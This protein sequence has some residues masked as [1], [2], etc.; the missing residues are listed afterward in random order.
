MTTRSLTILIAEDTAAT[1]L[2]LTKTIKK[3]GHHPI[4]A[5]NGQ[6]AVELFVQHQPDLVLCDINMPVMNG[7]E[8]IR[9]I[10]R[11]TTDY[12]APIL[13]LSASDQDDD[14]VRGLDAGA[15][16]YLAKPLHLD[17]LKAK[18]NA[19]QRLVEL[20]HVNNKNALDLKLAHQ[21]LE[22]EQ[23]HA[24]GLA[25]QMI[26][27]GD[28]HHDAIQYWLLPNLHFSGDLVTAKLVG[29]DK[30]YVMLA[31]STG[32]GLSAFL[33]TFTIAKIFH[34]MAQ[35]NYSL[36]GIITEM[37]ASAKSLLPPDRFVATN[38]FLVNFT[39][40]TIESWCGGLPDS[41]AINAK[42][43]IVKTFKSTNL[44][45]GILDPKQFNATTELW[46]WQEPVELF[47]YTDGVTEATNPG[48]KM[49]G[50]PTLL[51]IL[52]KTAPGQRFEQV[53]QAVLSHL[54]EEQ[55]YDDISLVRVDCQ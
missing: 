2:L 52:Q 51:D 35:K 48:G 34:A 41:Y 7:L 53:Q 24:K 11:L 4:L 8:A 17:I 26:N 54:E 45:V 15:D 42:G 32:H 31:D 33:P 20:Q 19:M 14:I 12:W 30:L 1:Q 25:S 10:R 43:D 46:H 29:Q 16:D 13:I 28:L 50:E 55:G 38:I 27:K 3:L 47:A 36:S 49:F 23:V 5:E 40:H 37:N 9:E 21:E 22:I 44:A 18:I 6:Q 39:H